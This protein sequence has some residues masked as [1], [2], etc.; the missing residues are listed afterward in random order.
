MSRILLVDSVP[1]RL[2]RTIDC[3]RQDDHVLT[4][5]RGLQEARAALLSQ[6]FEVILLTE[7]LLDGR[8]S[9]L[10]SAAHAIDSSLSIVL[11]CSESLVAGN[12]DSAFEVIGGEWRPEQIRNS[13]RRA[14]ER[15]AL[16]RQAVRLN[17]G[18]PPPEDSDVLHG[19]STAVRTLRAQIAEMASSAIPVLISGEAGTGKAQVAR[20]IH[21]SSARRSKPFFRV[22]AREIADLLEHGADVQECARLRAVGEGTL[23]IDQIEASSFP[24][25]N[26]L[27][28]L[29]RAALPRRGSSEM[30]AVHAR[31][32][33]AMRTT[34]DDGNHSPVPWLSES[35]VARVHV[36]ALRER[37]DDLP[38]LFDRMS[39]RE[40]YDLHMPLREVSAEVLN[41]LSGYRFPGNLRE[42]RN[43]IERAYLPSSGPELQPGDFALPSNPLFDPVSAVPQLGPASSERSFDLLAYLQQTEE[44]IIRRSLEMSGGAQAEAARSLGISRSLLAY[45]ISKYGIRPTEGARRAMPS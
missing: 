2:Q 9:D 26:L 29:Q 28:L 3:L 15:S 8:I 32:M 20:A 34:E 27:Q 39:R 40:A 36:P 42:L 17:A 44:A 25:P 33:L 13:V 31:I 37:R 6:I 4:A 14:A 35:E 12:Q 41:K 45:K 24:Q 38:E 18:F 1:E 7:D 22:V 16:I 5:A 43:M 10:I 23:F 11:A 30:F 21:A 19:I